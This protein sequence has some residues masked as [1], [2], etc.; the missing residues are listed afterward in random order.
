MTETPQNTNKAEY[1][2]NVLM[3]IQECIYLRNRIKV[4]QEKISELLGVSL[5]TVQRFENYKSM[6]N[7]LIW[8]YKKIFKQ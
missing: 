2:A 7:Y 6:N 8:G 1:E 3:E 5:K 4:S